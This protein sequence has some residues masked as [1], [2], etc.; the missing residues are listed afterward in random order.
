MTERHTILTYLSL[1][2]KYLNLSICYLSVPIIVFHAKLGHCA[3]PV[4]FANLRSRSV[5]PLIDPSFLILSATWCRASGWMDG[6]MDGGREGDTILTYL[7]RSMKYLNLSIC[8]LSV[9]IIVF[10]AKLGHCA[11]PVVFANLC[12]RSVHPLIDPSFPI[13]SAT[14]CRANSILQS[15]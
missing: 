8:Y 6:W 4:V 1:S 15:L 2:I 3:G 10:H 7:I 14:W 9:P 5:H 13:L 12:S 11:G